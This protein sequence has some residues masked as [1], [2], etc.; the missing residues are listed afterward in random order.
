MHEPEAY[1]RYKRRIKPRRSR[2]RACGLLG[3]QHLWLVGDR[4]EFGLEPSCA[5]SV[6][7]TALPITAVTRIVYWPGR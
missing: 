7:T 5:I 1:R 6:G 2:F 3:L 4:L